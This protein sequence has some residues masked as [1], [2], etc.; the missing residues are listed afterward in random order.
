MGFCRS[1]AP[2]PASAS[3]SAGGRVVP[4]SPRPCSPGSPALLFA[5]VVLAGCCP[6]SSAR[7]SGSP[8]A[9]SSR[10]VPPASPSGRVGLTSTIRGLLPPFAPSPSPWRSPW[11]WPWPWPSWS[12]TA[13]PSGSSVVECLKR[14]G[15]RKMLGDGRGGGLI[16]A[17]RSR[18]VRCWMT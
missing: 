2:W 1:S 3:A 7:G 15:G 17:R 11:P 13:V 18:R 16:A 8:A 6:C 14:E 10:G 4:P 5:S 12:T 9:A